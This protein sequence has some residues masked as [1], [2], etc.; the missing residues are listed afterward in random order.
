M[1]TTQKTIRVIL[2]DQQPSSA[3]NL[4]MALAGSPLIQVIGQAADRNETLQLCQLTGPDVVLINLL[5]PDLDGVSTVRLVSNQ[6]PQTIVLV[7]S[8]PQDEAELRAAME[9]GAAGYLPLDATPEYLAG[10]IQQVAE[11]KRSFAANQTTPPMITE[12]AQPIYPASSVDLRSSELAEAAR[13]QTSLLPAEPPTI[14]GWEL[15]VKMKP[16]RETSGDFYDFIPLEH[17]KVA[18]VIGDVSD[19]GLGAALFMAMTSTLFRTFI[20]RQPSMP[21]LI[22]SQVNERILS[23]SGGSSFVTTFL[24]VLEPNTGRLRYVNG[25]HVPPLMVGAQR[26]KTIDHLSRTGMALGVHPSAAWQQKLVKFAPGDFLLMYTDGILDAQNCDGVFYGHQ[27]LTQVARAR[28]GG[29]AQQ[30]VERILADVAQFT[31]DA[32]VNDDLIL[33]VLAR[34]K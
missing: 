8:E 24:S 10:V 31:G 11:G 6:F 34:K 9:A 28:P 33:L 32:P 27:R 3:S 29:S 25:G 4:G 1:T 18:I 2:V 20:P 15:A 30:I 7:F 22:M 23:D 12:T 17:G 13:I 21:A 14:P 16:A 5:M 26:G 19:K